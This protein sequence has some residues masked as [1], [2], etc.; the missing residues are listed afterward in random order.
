MGA[1]NVNEVHRVDSRGSGNPPGCTAGNSDE[2]NARPVTPEQHRAVIKACR[3]LE[4][5]LTDNSLEM[6]AAEACLSPYHFHRLFK[7]L[8]GVTPGQYKNALRRSEIQSRLRLTPTVTEALYASGFNSPSRFYSRTREM[9]G[10]SPSAWRAGGSGT[11]IDHALVETELGLLIVAASQFGVC[12]I[13]F[14]EDSTALTEQLNALFP[15]A[16]ILRGDP[17]FSSTIETIAQLV[18]FAQMDPVRVN[19]IPLDIQGT[20]FQQQVWQTL[21]TI[22]S[23]STISYAELANA[24]GRPGAHRAAANACGANRV[25][26]LIPCHRVTRQSGVSGGY[27]W[28]EHR[29][30][31][32]LEQ[33]NQTPS[34]AT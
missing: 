19:R 1:K 27:R 18:N 26:L 8:L 11:E 32:L 12:H 6:L 30:K 33:E 3:S 15:K 9:L 4:Q 2:F 5:E 17:I 21:R 23:G 34:V 24:I 13:A 20:V 16:S 28:G 29:K 7:R 31:T 14:G 10:M 25:A 22:P